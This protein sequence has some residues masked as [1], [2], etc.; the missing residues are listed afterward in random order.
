MIAARAIPF[1]APLPAAAALALRCAR[2][3]PSPFPETF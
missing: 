3:G 2:H 1:P